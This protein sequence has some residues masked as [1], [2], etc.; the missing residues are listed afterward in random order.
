MQVLA[1]AVTPVVLV[2]ATAV[3]ISGVNSRYISIADKMRFLA[4]EFRA[5]DCAP[6]R[7]AVIA[8][9]MV[10]FRERITLVAWAVRVLYVAVACF[11]AV[12]MVIGATLWR[13]TLE[14]TTLPLF[15]L[16]VL[17]IMAAIVCQLLELHLS[18]RTITLE[19]R[20]VTAD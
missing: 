9:Q 14:S 8:N 7:R 16:G 15:G 20:D 4:Q 12:V 13:R 17:L 2:S 18:N 5:G 10:I 6:A 11:I 19:V 3:L 1:A